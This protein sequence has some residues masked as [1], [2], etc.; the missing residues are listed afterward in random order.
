V[1]NYLKSIKFIVLPSDR[2]MEL[3][4]EFIPNTLIDSYLKKFFEADFVFCIEHKSL[5][6]DTADS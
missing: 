1:K 5:E 4:P 3:Y 6:T 2:V